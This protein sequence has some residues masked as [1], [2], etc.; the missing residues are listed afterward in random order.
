MEIQGGK[1]V[2]V[3]KLTWLNNLQ[4]ISFEPEMT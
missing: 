1:E 4:S 3:L 2:H